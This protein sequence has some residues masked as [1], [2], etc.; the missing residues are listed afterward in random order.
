MTTLFLKILNMSMAASWVVLVVLLLRLLFNRVPKWF[1]V[2][3]WGLVAIRL[4]C[5]AFLASPVSVLP[6]IA[7]NGV[8]LSEWMDEHIGHDA[9]DA[10]RETASEVSNGS[11]AGTQTERQDESATIANTIIPLLAVVWVC[12]MFV[13]LLYTAVSYW[14]LHQK[15]ETAVRYRDHIFQSEAVST[16]FVLGI[17][18]PKIY[19]PYGMDEQA[20]EHVLAH[21]Q[22]HIQ[23]KDH[24]WKPLGFL[25][26]TIHWFNPLIW[27]SYILLC[28]NIEWACDEKVIKNLD[29][30]QKADYTQT[31]VNCSVKGHRIAACPVAFGEVNIKKRVKS[32]LNYKKPSRWII[33]GTAILGIVAA[34]CLLTNPR[35]PVRNPCVREYVPG[36]PDVF[37]HVNKAAFETIH[38]DF[39]IG[40][41]WYG[42]AVFEDPYQ[43][44]CTLL[45][46]YGDGIALLREQYDLLPISQ[47]NYGSYKTYGWQTSSGP[48]EAVS[49]A[50]FVSKFF[51]I[52][53]NSFMKEY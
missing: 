15:T 24:W 16:P 8:V 36:S 47:W 43:A 42:K 7:E 40:A 23:R 18:R 45:E 48:A 9:A 3:L 21:E 17:I 13:F 41:D 11:A 44:Y 27:L 26:L 5:P 31:L 37:G 14:H 39:A 34:A 2:L 53:E 28:R 52:Y 25:L 22:A 29:C 50:H 19:L 30:E 20:L 4:I 32:V 6:E 35:R 49:Q 1:H 38:E 10:G 51:D 12:G 33:V 46:L